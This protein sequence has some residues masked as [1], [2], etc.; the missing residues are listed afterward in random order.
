MKRI[1]ARSELGKISKLKCSI[2]YVRGKSRSYDVIDPL[3]G[4]ICI[5][6]YIYIYMDTFFER[7]IYTCKKVYFVPDV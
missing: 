6:I 7:I 4:L 2:C 1:A 3:A 5:Y